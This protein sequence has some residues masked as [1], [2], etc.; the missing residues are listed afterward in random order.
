MSSMDRGQWPC[1]EGMKYLKKKYVTYPLQSKPDPSPRLEESPHT[2]GR[3][4]T[5][6]YPQSFQ[7]CW[8]PHRPSQ[9]LHWQYCMLLYALFSQYASEGSA[10]L[11][12]GSN[13]VLTHQWQSHG[14]L[15]GMRGRVTHGMLEKMSIFNYNS[16]FG[17]GP[18]WFY[19]GEMKNENHV[20][21]NL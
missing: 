18:T 10:L 15:T 9:P 19:S 14:C 7:G 21:C 12:L 2:Y 5:L 4:W 6:L 20:S 8:Q 13:G 1:T 17:D 16:I 3:G 11:I